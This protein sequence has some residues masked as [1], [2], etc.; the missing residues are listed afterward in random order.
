MVREVIWPLKVQRQLKTAYKYILKESY[1][2]A[3]IVKNDYTTF[4]KTTS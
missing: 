3:E 2:N 1:Q 4:D